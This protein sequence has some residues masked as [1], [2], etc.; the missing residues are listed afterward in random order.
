MKMAQLLK[1]NIITHF[2]YYRRSRL[3]LAFLLVFLVLTGLSCLP[4]FFTHSGVQGF[5]ALH[6]VYSMLNWF[7]LLFVAGVSL[8]VIS[9]HLR[10]RSLKMVFT[11][12]CSPAVWLFSAFLSAVAVSFV[13]NLAILG[14]ATLASLIWHL[15]V[16]A[17]LL[18]ASTY[19]FTTSVGLIAYMMLLAAIVHPA[20]AVTFAVI[21]NASMFYNVNMWT[22]SV[23][24]SGNTNGVLRLLNHLFH[25]IYLALPIVHVA[26]NKTDDILQS[27]HVPHGSWKYVLQSAGYTAALCLFC[28]SAALLALH[29]RKHI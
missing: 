6:Q 19:A 23:I 11:K 7:L 26:D 22:E 21:F 18:F 12:P 20:I 1:A 24:R 29:R 16:R 13:L 4:L 10:N 28:Y 15:P 17:G 8:F 5:N 3:L 27:L 2:A 9:S 25:Y 14:G